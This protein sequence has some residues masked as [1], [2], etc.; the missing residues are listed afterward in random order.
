MKLLLE[1]WKRY[2]TEVSQ[3]EQSYFGNT[4]KIADQI[5][6]EL[7]KWKSGLQDKSHKFLQQNMTTFAESLKQKIPNLT[8]MGVGKFRA[9]FSTDEDI[10]IKIDYTDGNIA[11]EQNESDASMGRLGEDPRFSYL[12][13]KSYL[14]HENSRWVILEK[15]KPLTGNYTKFNEFFNTPTINKHTNNQ[16]LITLYIRAC[17]LY[18]TKYDN[19]LRDI[20]G[21][22]N[23]IKASDN[24]RTQIPPVRILVEDVRKSK[25]F[26]D[27][28]RVCQKYKISPW[29]IKPDNVGLTE[30]NRFVIID[31]S[32]LE[33]I[34]KGIDA[35]DASNAPQSPKPTPQPIP[36]TPSNLEATRK[37][38][39]Q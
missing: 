38:V 36:S 29:E 39:K 23:K 5:I 33:E 32:K 6:D 11:K 14:S 4:I 25:L 30:D 20:M 31:S 21:P 2:I 13:A 19:L 34:N 15:V 8:F 35:I 17:L 18:E 1:N 27:L 9:V 12:F 10:I 7:D 28:V 16:Q 37:I 3:Q 26:T 22:I 24:I